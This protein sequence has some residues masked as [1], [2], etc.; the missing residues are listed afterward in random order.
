MHNEYGHRSTESLR[1]EIT[2]K[3]K[4]TKE[5]RK[6]I[7]KPHAWGKMRGWGGGEERSHLISVRRERVIDSLVD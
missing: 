7:R 5:K 6:I 4:S 2:N 3:E 1:L